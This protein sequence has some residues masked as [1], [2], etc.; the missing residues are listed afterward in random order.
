MT[1]TKD[2]PEELI[3][4]LITDRNE[5]MAEKAKELLQSK[6]VFIAVGAAHLGGDL[7]LLNLLKRK[8]YTIKPVT[9]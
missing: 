7:G 3:K 4:S 9:E 1:S 8:G 6:R 5:R 2:M